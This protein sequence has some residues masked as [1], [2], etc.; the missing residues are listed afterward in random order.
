M[1]LALILL[2]ENDL[3]KAGLDASKFLFFFQK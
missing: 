2:S 1:L 3:L